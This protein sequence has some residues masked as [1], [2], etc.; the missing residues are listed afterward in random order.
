MTTFE[1]LSVNDLAVLRALLVQVPGGLG[2]EVAAQLPHT[3]RESGAVTMVELA[4]DSS[5]PRAHVADGPLPGRALVED[6]TGLIGE[7]MV[8][9]K[10]GHLSTLEYAWYTDD[11]PTALPSPVQIRFA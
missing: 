11:V 8:W 3:Q 6:S 5:V 7:L 2:D 1:P 10:S 9:M 4:V